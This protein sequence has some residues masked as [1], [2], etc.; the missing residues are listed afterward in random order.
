MPMSVIQ[1]TG[2]RLGNGYGL[3]QRELALAP[4]PV[5]EGLPL[6]EGHDVEEETVAIPPLPISCSI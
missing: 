1:G 5:S 6:D 2:H 3:L 4:E